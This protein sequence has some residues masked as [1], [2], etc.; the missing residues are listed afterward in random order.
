MTADQI[1]REHQIH[2]SEATAG[3]HYTACPKCSHARERS[4]QK[5]KCLGVTING[6][7]VSWGCNHCGWTG[8][9]RFEKPNGHDRGVITY[10]YEDESGVLLFRKFARQTKSFGSAGLMA[11]PGG[12]T[13][14]AILGRSC[15]GCQS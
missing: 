1:L 12:L 14:L 10:D 7:S 13:A 5:L 4:H 8:G 15:I 6:A 9:D 3:R 2:L 11:R